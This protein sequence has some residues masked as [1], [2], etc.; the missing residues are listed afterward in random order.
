M[1]RISQVLFL[2]SRISILTPGRYRRRTISIF[3]LDANS[4]GTNLGD[5]SLP[6]AAMAATTGPCS[7]LIAICD[8][9]VLCPNSVPGPPVPGVHV[10]SVCHSQAHS[11]TC[12]VLMPASLFRL[13]L[14]QPLTLTGVFPSTRNMT[15]RLNHSQ[16]ALI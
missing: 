8:L 1:T 2:R 6:M 12:F 14:G 16:C 5:D 15:R 10:L 4:S 9:H 7:T 13:Q 3:L 11:R